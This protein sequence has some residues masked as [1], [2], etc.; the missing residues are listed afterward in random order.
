M[1]KIYI[2]ILCPPFQGSTII[3]HLL[4]S[5]SIVSSFLDVA[6]KSGESQW[7][8]KNHH[9]QFVEQNSLKNIFQN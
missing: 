9:L 6:T 1:K 3:V 7:L 2:F 4:N 8:Y 5:S